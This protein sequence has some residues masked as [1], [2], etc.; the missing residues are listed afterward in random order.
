VPVFM[1]IVVKMSLLWTRCNHTCT[2]GLL[3]NQVSFRH[4][5]YSSC[6]TNASMLNNT[7][8]KVIWNYIVWSKSFLSHTG[9]CGH[10]ESNR[11]PYLVCVSAVNGV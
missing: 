8:G 6:I 10:S 7:L 11:L 2:A 9:V 4:L 3:H 5:F 1:S